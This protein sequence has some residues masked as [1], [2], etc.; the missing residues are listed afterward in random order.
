MSVKDSNSYSRK[1]RDPYPRLHLQTHISYTS[2][3]P[4]QLTD[5]LLLAVVCVPSLCTLS[6]FKSDTHFKFVG[7]FV[8][9]AIYTHLP[10]PLGVISTLSAPVFI[11]RLIFLLS[12]LT[13]FDAHAT[14]I[15][16]LCLDS[17]VYV[18]IVTVSLSV[19]L[20][21]TV[22]LARLETEVLDL[23]VMSRSNMKGVSEVTLGAAIVALAALSF[24]MLAR[25]EV[26]DVWLQFYIRS[27]GETFD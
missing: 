16:P 9:L 21:L 22:T 6:P 12:P 19:G 10:A 26:G 20:I 17:H 3:P 14:L 7:R 25:G 4:Y 8:L 13:T 11:H 24:A 1:D 5:L 2:L 23:S 15:E 27:A 18:S